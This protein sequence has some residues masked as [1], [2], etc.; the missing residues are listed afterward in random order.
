MRFF[1]S[2]FRANLNKSYFT[3]RQDRYLHFSSQPALSQYC[4]DFLKTVSTFSYRLLPVTPT[5]LVDSPADRHSY[6][7][8]N[9]TL[10]WPDPQTHPHEIQQ[11][12]ET[13]LKQFQKTCLDKSKSVSERLSTSNCVDATLFP[14]I[15]AGQ[16]NIHEEEMTF[17]LLFRL[18]KS[19]KNAHRPL[20]DLTSGYFSLYK[21]YQDLILSSPGVDCRIVA[22][23]PKVGNTSSLVI[24]FPNLHFSGKRILRFKW[25]FGSNPGGVYPL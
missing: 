13:L 8:D 7:Q 12:A 17:Q 18:L 11:R 16:I 23:S 22:A 3:D 20:L 9:Y 24:S 5:S 14:L 6:T 19:L 1:E 10:H 2:T 25:H 21:P 15:Q 4:F